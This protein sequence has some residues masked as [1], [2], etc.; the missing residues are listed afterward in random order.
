[1]SQ[2]AEGLRARIGDINEYWSGFS[3]D[4]RM[5]R[6][7]FV[8]IEADLLHLKPLSEQVIQGSGSPL[9]V[10]I[11]NNL[12]VIQTYSTLSILQ[13]RADITHTYIPPRRSL[14]ELRFL[15]A[16]RCMYVCI[17][18]AFYTLGDYFGEDMLMFVKRSRRVDLGFCG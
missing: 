10:V 18:G 8:E 12:Y 11:L 17:W 13:P 16:S 14:P 7:D 2:S 6:V 3:K 5:S 15:T 4:R 1:M 9:V